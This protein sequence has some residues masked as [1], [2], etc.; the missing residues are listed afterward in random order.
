MS[1]TTISA[2]PDQVATPAS[3]CDIPCP[4]WCQKHD[5]AGEAETYLLHLADIDQQDC[6]APAGVNNFDSEPILFSLC[7]TDKVGPDGSWHRGPVEIFAETMT[8]CHT[9][10]HFVGYGEVRDLTNALNRIG[11]IACDSGDDF[12]RGWREASDKA[13]RLSS[14]NRVSAGCPCP[15]LDAG[16]AEEAVTSGST[17]ERS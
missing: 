7:R 13:W 10:L 16:T 2:T 15:V 11:A 5:D 4:P 9:V 12:A 3:T 14:E 17:G 8:T 6:S 1:E